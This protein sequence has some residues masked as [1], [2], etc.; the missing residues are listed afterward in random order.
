[1]HGRHLKRFLSALPDSLRI[2]GPI[3]VHP[4][5]Q[6]ALANKEPIVA[7][8]TTIVTH[9]MPYPV[10]L[11]TAQ[12]VESNVRKA[13]AIPAT[14]GIIGGRVKIGLE[15]R[16]LG[17][18]ADVENNLAVV[19]VSRRDIGPAIALKRDGGTTCSATLIFAALA[20]IKV[21]ATGGLGGVHR[22]G[23]ISMD[24]SADLH[25]LTR[26]PVGLVSAGVK[27]ILD[28]G[29]TLEYLETLGVPVISYGPTED[30]P[31]FYSRHSGFKS[32]WRVEDPISA[33]KVLYHQ[34]QL[35]MTN[36]ALFG[37]P[38]PERYQEV[39]EELQRHVEQAVK[40]AEENG[41]SRRGKE[42]TPWLLRRVGELT[43]GRSL[44]SNVALIENTA[45][46]GG[47][48]AVAYADLQHDRSEITRIA[49]PRS[50]APQRPS[51]ESA[52]NISSAEATDAE[53]LS[54]AKLV[55]IGSA[56]VD[57]TAQ[58]ASGNES[59]S[60]SGS[61]TTVPGTVSLNLGGVGRNVAEAAH[62]TLSSRLGRDSD[63][64]ILISPIGHDSFGRL[65]KN[66]MQ[67][68][69]MRTDGLIHMDS[70]R[71]AICNMVLDRAGGLTG[72]VADMDVTR[73]LDRVTA[74]RL[75]RKHQASLVAVDGNLSEE[76]LTSVVSHCHENGIPV[77]FEPTSV[78]KSLNIFPAVAASLPHADSN[79][80]PIAYV[81]PNTL[82]L[83]QMYQEAV[84]GPGELTSHSHWWTVVEAMS[85]GS[86]FR[87]DLEQ[88]ARL[89]A[90][91]HDPS[92]GTLSFLI[93]QGIAQMAIHLLPFFQHIVIKCGDRGVVTV[94]RVSGKSMETSAW[95]QERSNVR[96][97]YVV[98]H[99][100]SGTAVVQH[101]PAV[102]LAKEQI[103]NV[104]G[105]GD[106]L[107]G[108]M[109]AGLLHNPTALE[110]PSTLVDLI[111][112]AQDAAVLTLQSPCAVSPSL[113]T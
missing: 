101:F 89:N 48:I 46:V 17:Y 67:R 5:V 103:V 41:V 60:V 34:S 99:G 45:L 39:G 63:A 11:K 76:T 14:I 20:G 30:F 71:T 104:T 18:L 98:G 105:A 38:I 53:A 56:A 111:S 28:I 80:S 107:V 68:I 27:S 51:T 19:K 108:S 40:E 91:D 25:E 90:C 43:A 50:P 100:K 37:V 16:E 62:R 96:R 10:N 3:D 57:I 58:A 75:L 87:M 95:M 31:A 82:E 2:H 4:E 6:D 97:R 23:E 74:L 79:H 52:H 106:T 78:P 85:L 55:I 93:D 22:G 113:S 92:K 64:S 73:A 94:F 26:C 47:Q 35:G 29:R 7:L 84:A 36:G 81:A 65:L 49:L 44:T 83:M 61:H 15:P 8:E 109:L 69:R 112:K 13:G 102:R 88:L 21:F 66:E 24:V 12:S 77:F 70:V 9:G 42:A 59:D 1:M 32:P 72:G 110:D 33:A 86:V 54:P